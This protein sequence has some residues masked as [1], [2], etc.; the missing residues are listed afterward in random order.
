MN[1]NFNI[2]STTTNC[3]TTSQAAK[4][5][6]GIEIFKQVISSKEF[7][8][9]VKNFQWRTA[10]GVAFNRFHMSNGM[11]NQQ[12]CNTICNGTDWA[13]QVTNVVNNN[14]PTTV[15]VVPCCTQQEVM[16]CMNAMTACICI[17]MNVVNNSWYTPVH[18]A[19]AIMHEWCCWN[20]FTCNTT[21]T[22]VENWTVNTVPVACA[23]MCK[24]VCSTVCNTSEVTNW[25]NM[26]NN[27][28]FNYCACTSTYN[29]T[30]NTTNSVSSVTNIDTC[31]NVM[32][33]EMNWLTTCNNVTPDVTNRMTTLTNCINMMNEMKINLCNTSMDAC[34]WTCMP[35]NVVETVSAN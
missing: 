18:I 14:T 21:N 35:V 12:V 17:D 1:V 34:D 20:G 30:T 5:D 2:T 22:R 15:N 6:A 9:K 28:T 32:E 25:C 13:N 29:V 27:Q 24:D 19:C 11:S 4:V 3:F 26:I 8:T 16:N 33:M 7:Q 31:I 10:N 23:W